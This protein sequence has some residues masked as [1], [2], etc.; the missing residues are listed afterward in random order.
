MG[1]N[2]EK[3]KIYIHRCRTVN[4]VYLPRSYKCYVKWLKFKILRTLMLKNP[5]HMKMWKVWHPF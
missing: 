2:V 4:A 5:T 3:N 1:L